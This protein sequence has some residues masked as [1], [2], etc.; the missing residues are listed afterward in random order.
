M[1]ARPDADGDTRTDRI[2]VGNNRIL[3]RN[4]PSS[5]VPAPTARPLRTPGNSL[6]G[7]RV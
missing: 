5:E 1:S 2:P 3:R 4:R 7:R 6:G